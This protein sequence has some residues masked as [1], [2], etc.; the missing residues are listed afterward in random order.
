MKAPSS[1][2]A[3]N[4]LTQQYL[5]SQLSSNAK[6]AELTQQLAD[7]RAADDALVAQEK[8]TQAQTVAKAARKPVNFSTIL[9]SPAG[10]LGNPLLAQTK[11]G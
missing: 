2:A 6:Q 4:N 7:Q 9:T 1:S 5:Q 10:L 3:T 8:N 11:L